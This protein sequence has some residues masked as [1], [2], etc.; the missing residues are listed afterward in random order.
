MIRSPRNFTIG[1]AAVVTL[2]TISALPTTPSSAQPVAGEYVPAAAS[3]HCSTLM[4][5]DF[6]TLPEAGA[7]ILRVKSVAAV[8]GAPAYC[9]VRGTIQPNV[10][11]ALKLPEANWNGRFFQSGCG[12]YCG[13]IYEAACAEPLR[14]GY[15]CIATDSGHVA[16]PEDSSWTD[17]QWAEGN[18]QAALDWGGRASH[19]T[20]ST[21]KAITARFYGSA[22]AKSYFMGCSYGGHQAMVLAQRYPWDFDGIVGG[23][24]PNN[25]ASLMQQNV[26]ALRIAFGGVLRPVFSGRD[27]DLLH[28]QALKA[29]DMD[30]GVRDGLIGNPGACRVQPRALVCKPGESGDC[31]TPQAAQAAAL[32]YAGPSDSKGRRLSSGGWMPGTELYWSK[33]YRPDGTGLAALAPNYFRFMGRAPALGP[34]WSVK[35]YDFDIDYKRNDVMETLYAADNPD[36]RRFQAAGGKFINYAAGAIWVRSHRLRWIITRRSNGSSAAGHLPSL[37]FV[38]S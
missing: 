3:P 9:D 5:E 4:G 27:L 22:P 10:G 17:G 21:G 11:F 8:V 1:S 30:D 34:G 32:L 24:A 19:V 37:S 29:C 36:L 6:S 25:M 28:A 12:N 2:V 23:G 31:L 16:R 14:R 7:R 33:V 38:P 15:A 18:L 26:W 13:I 20:A 35:D